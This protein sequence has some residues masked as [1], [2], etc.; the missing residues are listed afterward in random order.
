MRYDPLIQVCQGDMLKHTFPDF[1]YALRG[2]NILKGYPQAV[3]HDPGFTYPIFKADYSGLLHT[4]DCRY[5]LPTGFL[6]APDVACVTSFSSEEL[7]NSHELSKSLSVN[8]EVSG[9]GWGVRFSA[10]AGYKKAT[11]ELASGNSVYVVS[12]A[13]CKYYT[14]VID[15]LSPPP[16]DED[17][18]ALAKKMEKSTSDV[19][20]F[21]DLYGTHFL[22]TIEFGAKFIYENKIS[23]EN[24]M[25]MQS[26]N[27][28]VKVQASYSGLFSLGGGFGMDS[29]QRNV[30]VS[31]S[32]KVETSTVTVGA[33]PPST[34]DA[35]EWASTVKTSPL[36]I[37]YKLTDIN[38]LFTATF[39]KDT[40]INYGLVHDHLQ[41]VQHSGVYCRALKA[42]GL[43]ETCMQPMFLDD[44]RLTGHYTFHKEVASVNS[45]ARMCLESKTCVATTFTRSPRAIRENRRT[46][47]MYGAR[48][49][50]GP[51]STGNKTYSLNYISFVSIEKIAMAAPDGQFRLMNTS[52]LGADLSS[53][54][55]MVASE[56]ACL[57]ACKDDPQCSVLVYCSNPMYLES[58]CYGRAQNCLLYAIWGVKTVRHVRFTTTTFIANTD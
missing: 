49:N 47:Y 39:M 26:E 55:G 24:Y 50:N 32:K 23:T 31:F 44:T 46:C 11:R 18:L 30:A 2:Y 21:L 17:F 6:V 45:C 51:S 1:D 40:G 19:V 20:R 57:V 29:D 14:S 52:V 25:S 34:G 37:E 27:I 42:R 3:G 56:V 10:S 35:M 54:L 16:F 12:K 15:R 9:G 41:H 7:T 13:T 38:E 8:A 28:N 36:P 4:A 43:V 33:A 48:P 5:R 22:E 53:K 58:P